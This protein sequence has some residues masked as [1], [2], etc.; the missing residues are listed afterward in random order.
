VNIQSMADIDAYVESLGGTGKAAEIFGVTPPAVSNWRNQGHF[1]IR[2]YRKVRSVS[3]THGVPF[4]EA[5]FP[6]EE[7]AA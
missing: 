5:L 1:P 7:S 3:D 4:S 6:P 2:L